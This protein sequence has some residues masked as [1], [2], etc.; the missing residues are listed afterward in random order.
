M[1]I[2]KIAVILTTGR[3]KTKTLEK[4]NYRRNDENFLNLPEN[5][6][7]ENDNLI[8]FVKLIMHFH[9]FYRLFAAGP[10]DYIVGRNNIYP[11]MFFPIII[12][13]KILILIFQI[14]I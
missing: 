10:R 1:M 4:I 8:V 2:I 7:F 13:I 3:K 9:R 12:L 14:F 5:I 6:R 11:E